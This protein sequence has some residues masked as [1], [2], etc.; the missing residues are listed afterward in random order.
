MICGY[1]CVLTR[2]LLQTTVLRSQALQLLGVTSTD[3]E[4]E[5]CVFRL[6]LDGK[7]PSSRD[8]G[9]DWSQSLRAG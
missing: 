4:C 5:R 3:Y 6:M 9:L 8:K 1:K 7:K 2:N